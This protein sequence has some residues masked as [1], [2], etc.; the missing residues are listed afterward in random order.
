M[1]HSRR[2]QFFLFL[3]EQCECLPLQEVSETV[4]F[5]ADSIADPSFEQLLLVKSQEDVLVATG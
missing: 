5:L 1:N 4:E 2:I 3:V